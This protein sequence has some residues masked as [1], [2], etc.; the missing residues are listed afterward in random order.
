VDWVAWGACFVITIAPS[1]L[2]VSRRSGRPDIVEVL[3]SFIFPFL[4]LIA[5]SLSYYVGATLLVGSGFLVAYTLLSRSEP[6]LNMHRGS[7]LI[8]VSTEVF[9]LLAT[10]SAGAVSAIL[11]LQK[12]ALLDLILG[13]DLTDPLVHML[14]I[15]MEVFYLARPLFLELFIALAVVATISLLFRDNFQLAARMIFGCLTGKQLAATSQGRLSSK[16]PSQ[17]RAGFGLR[18]SFPYLIMV[19]SVVLGVTITTYP[20]T[21]AKVDFVLGSDMW[22]YAERLRAMMAAPNPLSMLEA[23]RGLF[24]LV[25]FAI[26]SLTHLEVDWV[27]MLAPALCSA[28]LAMSTFALVKEGTDRP[29][30]AGLA[31]L[32]SVVSAQTSL[33]MGAGILANWFSLSLMNF[34]FALLF[35]SIRSNSKRAAAACIV[36]SLV[37]LGSYTYMW[38]VTVAILAAVLVATLL[39]YRSQSRP[40][41]RRESTLVG[42]VLVGT[43][44]L[45]I[46]V[47]YV[48]LIPLLGHVPGWFDPGAWVNLGWNYLFGRPSF[49]MLEQA[50]VALEQAFDFAG[51]RIDLPFLT[52]LSLVGLADRA[53]DGTFRRVSAAMVLV[54]FVLAAVSPDLYL[55]WRGLY[56]IPL[57]LTGA[58]GTES[59][60]RRVNTQESPWTSHSRLAFA[61]V[62]TGYVILAHLSYS[63]RAVELLILVVFAR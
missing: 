46:L 43:L 12:R 21:V 29:W 31:A 48:A 63:L 56:M 13:Y 19:A 41:W 34:M 44:A 42:T 23:D 60:V 62:F 9:A 25:L 24:V 39:S 5:M 61:G 11:L 27:L 15:D 59:I 55:T 2:K 40:Q 49:Q 33:G 6:L 53:W 28:L 54:P 47:G 38:V 8:V 30:L 36:F 35:T 45:P 51:N 17:S 3:T 14:S 37:L 52:I 50:P 32:L 20:Y 22:F 18:A 26:M 7:A 10:V 4:S 57:Y 16:P 1:I 58:L